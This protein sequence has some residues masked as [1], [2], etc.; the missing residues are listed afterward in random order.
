MP[1]LENFLHNKE[2]TMKLNER[3]NLRRLRGFNEIELGNYHV[4]PGEILTQ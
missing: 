1:F 2:D 3:L 4:L